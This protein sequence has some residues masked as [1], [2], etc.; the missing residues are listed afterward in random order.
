MA[1][2]SEL[3]VPRYR[4]FRE[5]G[6]RGGMFLD[7]NWAVHPSPKESIMS[8]RFFRRVKLLPGLTLNLAKKGPSLSEQADE[9][10]P[11]L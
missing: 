2:F 7:V 9:R 5:M 4:E 10:N 1:T 11:G 8:L 6:R 3:P